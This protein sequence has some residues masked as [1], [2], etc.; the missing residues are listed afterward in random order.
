MMILR[1]RT[2]HV[3]R[4]AGVLSLFAFATTVCSFAADPATLTWT[5]LQPATSFP[6]RAGFATAYDPVSKKVIVFGGYDA[7][8]ALYNETWMFNGSTWKKANAGNT[9]PIGRLGPSMAYDRRIKKIVMFGGSAGLTHLNDTWLFDGA[10]LKWTLMHPTNTPPGAS[11][12]MLFTDPLNGHVDMFGGRR[13]QFYSRDT[14]QWSGTDWKLLNPT[15]SPFPRSG[16]VAVLDQA[17]KNVLV[18]GGFSDSWVTQNTWSLG[19]PRL[20]PAQPRY[21]AGLAL[22][23]HGRLRAGI[24]AGGRLRRWRYRSGPGCYLGLGWH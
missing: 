1:Q 14:Y 9:V 24:G 5:Q 21:S 7:N 13:N 2:S 19:R 12:A 16:G 20:D 23:H 4:V 17:G 15:N 8:G 3:L 6:A 10:T 18:F 22:L 11:N